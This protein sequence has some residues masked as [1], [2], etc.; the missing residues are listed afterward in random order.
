VRWINPDFGQLEEH[1]LRHGFMH[2]N[3]APAT[4]NGSHEDQGE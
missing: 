1:L 4:A 3:Q 2:D